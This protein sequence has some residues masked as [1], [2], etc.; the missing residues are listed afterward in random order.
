KR[1]HARRQKYISLVRAYFEGDPYSKYDGIEE[2][3]YY[4][5]R[6]IMLPSEKLGEAPLYLWNLAEDLLNVLGND[7][8][9]NGAKVTLKNVSAEAREAVFKQLLNFGGLY[10]SGPEGLLD[11]A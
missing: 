11:W 5:W 3:N 6:D 4:R 2:A 9:P 1:R 10:G 8:L 7:I